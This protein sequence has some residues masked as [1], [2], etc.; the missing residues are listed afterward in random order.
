MPT[1]HC[2]LL[3]AEDRITYILVGPQSGGVERSIFHQI[4][5]LGKDHC[6]L[7]TDLAFLLM[8]SLGHKG[9]QIPSSVA[10]AHPA[11]KEAVV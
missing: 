5:V 9:F 1:Y 6:L 10:F 7:T 4:M 8:F 11:G 3:H 2:L